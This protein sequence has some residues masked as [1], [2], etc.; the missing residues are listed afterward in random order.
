[1]VA[2]A[3]PPA[4]PSCVTQ[5]PQDPPTFGVFPTN[6]ELS[7][8][9]T[10]DGTGVLTLGQ[11]DGVSFFEDV[12]Y[13]IDGV[14]ATSSTVYLQPG[15]Y[16]VTVTTKSPDDGLDGPTVWRVTVTGGETC[17][18]LETLALT[19]APVGSWLALAGVLMAIGAGILA[20][21]RRRTV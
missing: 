7:E 6:A 10:A 17:G 5:P 16:T 15:T 18:E 14:P 19:G 20:T 1:V 2:L 13:Y 21:R 11:V 3:Y 9:C 4:T 12:N 8:Q